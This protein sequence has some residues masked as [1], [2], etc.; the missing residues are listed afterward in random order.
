M[1]ECR[2]KG[3]DK[4]SPLLHGSYC[5]QRHQRVALGHAVESVKAFHND[6][7]LPEEPTAEEVDR[8]AERAQRW[9]PE[10]MQE[11]I[12]ELTTQA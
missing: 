1:F 2:L 12:N 4:D 11:R 3:C 10:S 7:P 6:D 8:R 9:D 5:S